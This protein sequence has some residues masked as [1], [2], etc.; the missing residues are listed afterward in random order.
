M[1]GL[2]WRE[3]TRGET[4]RGREGGR[5]GGGEGG[6]APSASKREPYHDEENGNLPFPAL[7]SDPDAL[8]VGSVTLHL[9]PEVGVYQN[10]VATRLTHHCSREE[11][12]GGGVNRCQGGTVTMLATPRCQFT[13]TPE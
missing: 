13:T 7:G 8:L 12:G 5:E 1:C 11:G 4:E 10:S 2:V 6:Q 9:R 3:Q